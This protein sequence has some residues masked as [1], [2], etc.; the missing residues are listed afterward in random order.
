MRT[1][2]FSGVITA[3]SSLSHNGG[4]S[5]GVNSKLRREKFVQPD[6][7]V[8]EVPV[9]SG[10]SLRGLIR[11]RGMFHLC[12]TLGYGVDEEKGTVGAGLSLPAFHFLFSGGSLTSDGAKA[13]NLEEARE[14]R[15]LIPLVG[16]FGGALGNIILPGKLDMGKAIPICVETKHLLPAFLAD[17]A[18]ASI[19]D[20]TQEEMYTRKDDEKNEH[21]R[22]V[23]AAPARTLLDQARTATAL[24]TKQEPQ[25]DTGQKQQMMYYVETLAA[26]TRLYWRIELRDV[27]DL[28]FEA[29][30]VA[31]SEFSRRPVI[32]GKGNVGHGEVAVHFDRWHSIDSRLRENGAEVAHP[33][34]QAYTE[35][36]RENGAAIKAKLAE[37]R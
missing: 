26:G 4:Q 27:S 17:T 9:I 2:S 1:Y 33:L 10:N 6:G 21:L 28:E 25:A 3:L 7:T 5:H 19:W 30:A 12:R 18:T 22:S 24:K 11:D 29:F 37:M 34:G 20:Y 13:I 32:G 14:M 23:I 8:E 31:L 16:I 15:R 36:L 35:H